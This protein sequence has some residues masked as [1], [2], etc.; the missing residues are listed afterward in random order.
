MTVVADGQ[1]HRV[2]LAAI[3]APERDQ[4]HGKASG[5]ALRA[6]TLNRTVRVEYDKTDRYVVGTVWTARPDCRQD[7]ALGL[8]AVGLWAK[9]DPVAPWHW[10][11]Q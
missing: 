6:L 4:R 7:W 3:D 10:Q 2:R 8:D 11:R 5:D 9:R 1:R